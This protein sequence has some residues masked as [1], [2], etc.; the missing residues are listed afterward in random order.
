MQLDISEQTSTPSTNSQRYKYPVVK[1]TL[2]KRWF[3]IDDPEIRYNNGSRSWYHLKASKIEASNRIKIG[4]IR[5]SRGSKAHKDI[6]ICQCCGKYD[7]KSNLPYGQHVKCR[8]VEDHNR[9]QIGTTGNRTFTIEQ[10][11]H[12]LTVK[13]QTSVFSSSWSAKTTS[14]NSPAYPLKP[15]GVE[16]Q[17]AIIATLPQTFGASYSQMQMPFLEELST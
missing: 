4:T 1:C 6:G 2:S 12:T 9:N 11:L 17:K 15:V 16:N 3:I 7:L 14:A 13:T 5:H 8:S 10:W